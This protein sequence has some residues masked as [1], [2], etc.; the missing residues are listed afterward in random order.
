MKFKIGFLILLTSGLSGCYAHWTGGEDLDGKAREIADSYRYSKYTLREE[1][2]TSPEQDAVKVTMDFYYYR[3]PKT[4]SYTRYI[5]PGK[6]TSPAFGRYS[7]FIAQAGSEME[8]KRGAEE[9]LLKNILRE[10]LRRAVN[11]GF[12]DELLNLV[13]DDATRADVLLARLIQE[14]P[15][16]MGNISDWEVS[17]YSKYV[18]PEIDATTLAYLIQR[19]ILDES[20]QAT[21]HCHAVL[22]E[23]NDDR[24][25]ALMARVNTALNRLASVALEQKRMAAFQDIWRGY[26]PV[27]SGKLGLN[28]G[29]LAFAEKPEAV[30]GGLKLELARI[31]RNEPSI[32]VKALI[33]DGGIRRPASGAII[34]V[35]GSASRRAD[36]AGQ[37]LLEKP[38]LMSSCLKGDLI[39]A[40]FQF[41]LLRDLALDFSRKGFGDTPWVKDIEST[42]LNVSFRYEGKAKIVGLVPSLHKTE[43]GMIFKKLKAV[44]IRGSLRE[45]NFVPVVIIKAKIRWSFFNES[46]RKAVDSHDVTRSMNLSLRNSASYE[47]ELSDPALLEKIKKYRSSEVTIGFE[48]KDSGGR[49]VAVEIKSSGKFTK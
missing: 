39:S 13:G 34:S 32:R 26:R 11:E 15:Q 36:A 18:T 21:Y 22:V 6:Y 7:G 3:Q 35:N 44:V 2:V 29:S 25:S 46:Q 10:P 33:I 41:E 30:I 37:I 47:I 38:F 1:P 48:G 4:L 28:A 12:V 14:D 45:E 9:S 16:I 27:L 40:R 23:M 31:D 19:R 5:I 17:R 42:V 8:A 49:P 20:A 43:S 24:R